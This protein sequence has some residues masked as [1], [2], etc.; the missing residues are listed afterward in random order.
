[1]LKA[2]GTRYYRRR[3]EGLE[4]ILTRTGFKAAYSKASI[5]GL[6]KSQAPM[7]LRVES[8]NMVIVSLCEIAVSM[9]LLA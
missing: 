5:N 3:R 8:N 9:S 7:A 1:L 2:F 6:I 4:P